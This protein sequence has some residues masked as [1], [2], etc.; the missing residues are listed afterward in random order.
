MIGAILALLLMQGAGSPSYVA[1]FPATTVQ[2]DNHPGAAK[3]TVYKKERLILMEFG[4]ELD[5]LAGPPAK[6]V[7]NAQKLRALVIRNF[8]PLSYDKTQLPMQV[9]ANKQT[10]EIEV[11]LPT[12]ASSIA[13]NPEMWLAFTEAIED[14]AHDIEQ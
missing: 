2:S 11:H 3:V 5:W 12:F 1:N 4:G 7:A 14:A 6:M 10:K 9:V 13:A 8:G